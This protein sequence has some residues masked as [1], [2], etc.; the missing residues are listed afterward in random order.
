MVP[1]S[2]GFPLVPVVREAALEH[3]LEHVLRY[4]LEQ[5]WHLFQVDLGVFFSRP[6]LVYFI[7][8]YHCKKIKG[9]LIKEK[10]VGNALSNGAKVLKEIQR[11]DKIIKKRNHVVAF[12]I[13]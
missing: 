11:D 3:S 5:A 6:E 10:M 8:G 7:N 9:R 12:S 4:R 1:R 13:L 2:S